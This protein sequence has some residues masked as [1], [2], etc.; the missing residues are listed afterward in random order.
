MSEVKGRT[1]PR[2]Y[3]PPL[4]ELTPDTSL[5]FAMCDFARDILHIELYPWQRWLLVHAFEIVGSFDDSWQFRYRTVLTLVARQNGKTALSKVISAFFLFV[6]C[7]RLVIGTSTNLEAAEE[8]WEGVVDIAQESPDLSREVER[9]YRSAGNKTLT[10]TGGR[11]YKVATANRR[12][13]RGKSGDLVLLDELREHQTWEAYDAVSNTTMA[14]PNGLIW[15]ISNAGDGTSCV[16]RYL[17]AQAHMALGDPDGICAAY[18]DAREIEQDDTLGIFEWS[19]APGADPKSVDAWAQA[20]PA[21]GYGL[22]TLRALKSASKKPAASFLTENLCQWVTTSIESAFPDGSWEG[23][24]DANSAIAPDSPVW[25]GVDVSADR[26]HA[27]IAAC[28]LRNDGAWHGE[29]IAYRAGLGWLEDAFQRL[30]TKA[31][32]GRV[33]VAAQSK[34]SPVASMLSIISAVDGVEIVPCQG[35][36]VA[37]WCGRLWDAVNASNPDG[38]SRSD[39]ARLMH[40]PQPRLDLAAATAV[41]KPMGDGAWAWDRAKSTEDASPLVAL[42]MAF[43]AATQGAA[44]TDSAYQDHELLFV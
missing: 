33:L 8:V 22:L 35:P 14:K 4:R 7:V 3:T 9:V 37:G 41:T 11:R 32:G 31:T 13:G 21:L 15:C 34:G 10:L 25:Y 18:A 30:A 38:E 5:G 24:I 6:L 2:I 1:E 42:T 19:S 40:R 36:D 17:R 29:L 16:L 28:G 23:G 43:G 20:N 39:V 12:G 26:E 27:S 44:A